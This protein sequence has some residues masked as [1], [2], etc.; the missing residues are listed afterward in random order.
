MSMS[1]P[2]AFGYRKEDPVHSPINA[3][4]GR[5][6]GV[7]QTRAHQRKPPNQIE[8]RVS[9]RIRNSPILSQKAAAKLEASSLSSSSVMKRSDQAFQSKRGGERIEKSQ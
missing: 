4:A 7:L 9:V 3:H 1:R 5:S 8:S 2:G 6:P